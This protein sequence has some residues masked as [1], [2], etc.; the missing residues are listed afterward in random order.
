[1]Y[2]NKQKYK[3]ILDKKEWIKTDPYKYEKYIYQT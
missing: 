1:M 2:R 3:N